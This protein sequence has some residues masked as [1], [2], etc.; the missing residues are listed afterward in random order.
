[1]AKAF[2]AFEEIRNWIKTNSAL[3]KRT[4]SNHLRDQFVGQAYPALRQAWGGLHTGCARIVKEQLFPYPDFPPWTYEA[5][6]FVQFFRELLCKQHLDPTSQEVFRSGISL[7]QGLSF[8]SAPSPVQAGG[9]HA[10]VIEDNQ[11]I[12][13]K[14]IR[15]IPE[16]AV[17]NA[18]RLPIQQ[19][20]ARRRAINQRFLCDQVFGEEIVEFRD[21]HLQIIET[22]DV[23][24]LCRPK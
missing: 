16:A 2:H 14:E 3:P 18:A 20:H 4:P 6:P 1:M 15:K 12:W 5:F 17:L 22:P 24:L 9:K 21:K 7:T 11:I 19:Q 10:R 13:A 23:I 8:V